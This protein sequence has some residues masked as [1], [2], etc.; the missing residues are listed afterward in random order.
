MRPFVRAVCALF[1]LA[2]LCAFSCDK[3]GDTIIVQ[4]PSVSSVKEA[5]VGCSGG[6][7]V[8]IPSDGTPTVFCRF[9]T[10]PPGFNQYI[11]SVAWHSPSNTLFSVRYVSRI[12]DSTGFIYKHRPDGTPQLFADRDEAG[13]P[14]VAYAI[15]FSPSGELHAAVHGN[16][17][18]RILKF[19]AQGN[20]TL[21]HS[22]GSAND[23]AGLCFSPSGEIFYSLAGDRKL[24]RVKSQ[25]E[26]ETWAGSSVLDYPSEISSNSAGQIF[27]ASGGNDR[28]VRVSGPNV[29]DVFAQNT[30][31]PP[32]P[33][34]ENPRGLAVDAQDNVWVGNYVGNNVVVFDRWGVLVPPVPRADWITLTGPQSI[35]LRY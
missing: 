8:R 19:D 25:T 2:L 28:I 10:A 21:V 35:A 13:N 30:T 6:L 7:I 9:E 32:F 18:D 29:Y 31:D 1:G 14:L 22:A 15:A 5:F 33:W 4:T 17:N 34:V 20:A 3:E 16:N 11:T 27:V 12:G 23:I 24:R 26:Y